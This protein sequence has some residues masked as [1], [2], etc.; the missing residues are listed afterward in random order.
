M[1]HGLQLFLQELCPRYGPITRSLFM[2]SM[3]AQ[4]KRQMGLP[5]FVL[6]LTCPCSGLAWGSPDAVSDQGSPAGL[7]PHPRAWCPTGS[8]S[9]TPMASSSP[10]G[11]MRVPGSCSTLTC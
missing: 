7:G 8:C 9:F 4:E 5:C 6:G 2:F 1:L 10:G 11:H 3:L